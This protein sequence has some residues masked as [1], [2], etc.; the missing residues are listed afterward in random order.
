MI[1]TQ[2][3]EIE[4]INYLDQYDEMGETRKFV[5]DFIKQNSNFIKSTEYYKKNNYH[6]S[7]FP[8]YEDRTIFAN[9]SRL[10]RYVSDL[11]TNLENDLNEENIKELYI[12]RSNNAIRKGIDYYK[13]EE[14]IKQI[15]KIG[16]RYKSPT[17]TCNPT[18]LST[19]KENRDLYKIVTKI[20]DL[21]R[22][23][24]GFDKLDE[25]NRRLKPVTSRMPQSMFPS[26]GGKRRKSS[27]KRS[28][29]SSKKSKKRSKKSTKK[30]SKK[31]S[32]K[33]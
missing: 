18:L 8:N 5:Y 12:P 27:K 7:L 3:I 26:K 22:Q 1:S 20:F 19:Q 23:H 32:T 28:K 21:Y 30:R 17:H 6:I 11:K 10:Q 4:C 14:D 15:N 13:S 2:Q 24:V 29:K 31:R 9:R 16:T 33:K 25:N